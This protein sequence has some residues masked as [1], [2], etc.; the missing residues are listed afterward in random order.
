MILRLTAVSLALAT[1]VAGAAMSVHA[2]N[3][4]AGAARIQGKPNLSGLWQA[5]N[6]ANWDIQAHEARPGP[7]QFGA[8]FSEPAGIGVVEGNEIPYKPE[9][10]KR[11]QENFAKRWAL[12]PEAKCYMAGVPRA[13]YQPFPFQIIQGTDRIIVAYPFASASRI[14]HM[15]DVGES[16]ADSWMGWSRGRWDGETLV[17]DVRNLI[18]DTWFDRAGNFHSDA[19]H[20][21]ERYTPMGENVIQYEATIEDPN[22]FTRTWKMSMPLYRRLEKNAQFLEFKCVPFAEEFLYGHLKKPGTN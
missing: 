16:P 1:L 17:V 10:L 20:V 14:I 22:V 11:K 5:V 12:D 4:A 8:L 19:L 21:T 15:K 18:E 2:Q 6:E 3:Q 9:M 13:T 7:P